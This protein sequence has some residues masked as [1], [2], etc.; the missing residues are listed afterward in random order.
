MGVPFEFGGG[1]EQSR[2][3]AVRMLQK[4]R[5]GE[6]RGQ[7]GYTVWISTNCLKIFEKKFKV[8]FQIAE[9]K[10]KCNHMW[11]SRKFVKFRSPSSSIITTLLRLRHK[12]EDFFSPPSCG[13]ATEEKRE[14]MLLGYC[15]PPTSSLSSWP[16][17][18]PWLDFLSPPPRGRRREAH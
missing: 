1:N 7:F 14:E 17:F 6:A 10:E 18:L 15:L 3:I 8:S 16:E 9:E 2:S 11:D 12:N 4:M 5:E 13:E